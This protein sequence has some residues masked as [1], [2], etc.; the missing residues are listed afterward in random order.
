[1]EKWI[2]KVKESVTVDQ[3]QNLAMLWWLTGSLKLALIILIVDCGYKF[4]HG[5]SVTCCIEVV[6]VLNRVDSRYK[7]T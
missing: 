4:N 2:L 5:C 3:N 7:I 1:M 6:N